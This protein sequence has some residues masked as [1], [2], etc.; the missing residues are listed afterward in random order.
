MSKGRKI[1]IGGFALA[2][3]VTAAILSNTAT[4]KDLDTAVKEAEKNQV[5]QVSEMAAVG[6]PAPAFSLG[7][8]DDKQVVKLADLKGKPVVINFWASWCGP[9][10]QEMPDLEQIHQQYKDKVAF[11]GINLTKLD[12]IPDVET[13]VKKF[14]VTYPILMDPDDE[15][16]RIY[17]AYSIPTTYAIDAN[18]IIVEKRVGAISKLAMDGMLQRLV[19]GK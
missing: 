12:K 18:G 14:G 9:C 19:A 4:K 16:S 13:A 7:K 11:Y 6:S 5:E 10:K 2:V 3:L 8:L 1:W 17:Q 15:V